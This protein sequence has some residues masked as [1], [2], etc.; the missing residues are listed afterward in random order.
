MRS[1]VMFPLIRHSVLLSFTM[2]V[3]IA[4]LVILWS[5]PTMCVATYDGIPMR[6]ARQV[7]PVPTM[8]CVAS[9]FCLE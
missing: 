7:Q 2:K 6:L 8:E 5:R 9:C 4:R 3:G 1:G